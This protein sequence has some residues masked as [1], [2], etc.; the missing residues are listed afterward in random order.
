MSLEI[1]G[2]LSTFKCR[3]GLQ[4][5]TLSNEGKSLEGKRMEASIRVPLRLWL[6]LSPHVDR[7]GLQ[8]VAGLC[9]SANMHSRFCAFA[10]SVFW[11]FRTLRLWDYGAFAPFGTLGTLELSFWPWTTTHRWIGLTWFTLVA[12]SDRTY[13]ILSVR[14]FV[15][16]FVCFFVCWLP[17]DVLSLL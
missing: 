1:T 13:S 4:R 9:R 17:Q 6:L 12:H 14:S 8:A 15:R 3:Q 11:Q 5:W 7:G 2:S 16:S 10:P